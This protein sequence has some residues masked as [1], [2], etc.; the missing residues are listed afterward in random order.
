M[1]QALSFGLLLAGGVLLESALTGSGLADVVQGKA[2]SIPTS[3]AT[4]GGTAVGTPGVATVGAAIANAAGYVNPFAGASVKAERID[5]GVDYAGT[6]NIGA[7]GAGV[8]TEV[9][10][11]GGGSG[12]P[13]GGYVEYKLLSGPQA[14]KLIYVAEGVRPTVVKGQSVKAGQIIA[15]LVPGSSTGI[16]TGLGSGAGTGTYASQH[17]GYSEGEL[18]AAGQWFSNFLA[19]L[20]AAP[21]L[22]E[23]RSPVGTAP[24]GSA[25]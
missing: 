17:G 20:G 14:G 13:G 12:W 11:Y 16:E 8:I 18:T 21:G 6:G 7:I 25:F 23:G 2:G 24:S 22:V 4:I 1:N 19:Q 10:P 15:T 3:G 9:F 5:Q